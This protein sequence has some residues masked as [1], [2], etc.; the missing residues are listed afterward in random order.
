MS[1]FVFTVTTAGLDALVDAQAGKIAAIEISALGLSAA[2]VDVSPTLIALPGEFKRIDTFSGQS[3]SET[4][5]HM[6]ALDASAE[7]YDVRSLALYL[8]D[9]TLFAAY[10]RA[11]GPLFRKVDI[12]SFLFSID[13]AFSE[14]IAGD[15]AFGDA[16]FLYPPATEAVKG[17]AEIATQVEVDDEADDGR[18]VT[19]LK[20]ATRLAEVL[21]PIIQSIAD[22][23]SARGNADAS[24]DQVIGEEV[25][26]RTDAD[27]ALQGLI[28]AL[29]ARTISGSGLVTGGGT[30]ASNRVLQVLAA[31]A[32]DVLAGTAADRAI[33][34][35]ALGGIVKSVG[36]SGYISIPTADP[37]R[38][39]VLQ[40]GRF[41]AAGDALTTVTFPLAFSQPAF[42]VVA[43]GSDSTDTGVSS[44]NAR[45]R[46]NT[47]TATGFA[48]F[49][50]TNT[51]E[52]CTFIAV[53]EIDNS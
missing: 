10:S 39:V 25:Q 16:S 31:S 33:T 29:L 11:E 38:L 15:I 12:A 53:G 46:A 47:I 17:V 48:A 43:D 14:A 51:A 45:V 37:A 28:D 8:A 36:Q 3:V 41:T 23:A 19:P 21:A 13:I 52:S 32:A 40:W 22:E 27:A 44:N 7:T 6:T 9:G 24:L 20:L 1:G 34:P 30:L 4:I 5:I 42:S 50:A 49:S 2:I 26:Q 18:I 35:A